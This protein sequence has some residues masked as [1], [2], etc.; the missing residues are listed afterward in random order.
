M[1]T[2]V[3]RQNRDTEVLVI[4]AGA[5]GLMAAISSAE[6]G[7]ETVIVERNEFAGKKLRITGKG[8]C[9]VTTDC[10]A[11]EFFEAVNHNP[12]MSHN[13]HHRQIHVPLQTV[14]F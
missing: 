6:T 10:T 5:A 14:P 8:R 12:K 9:N 11:R 13:R 4:G 3:S 7:A 1:S 2:Q